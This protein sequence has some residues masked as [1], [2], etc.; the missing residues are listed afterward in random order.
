[1]EPISFG[2]SKEA[3]HRIRN[4]RFRN[5]LKF[6]L[7]I[8]VVMVLFLYY[9]FHLVGLFSSLLIILMSYFALW[10]GMLLN[11]KQILTLKFTLSAQGVER[12]MQNLSPAS[13]IWEHLDI[14]RAKDGDVV[15]I[16]TS[17]SKSRH[18]FKRRGSRIVLPRELDDIDKAL[19]IINKMKKG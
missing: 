14:E 8:L 15:L 5:R 13:I 1:M 12:T 18:W 3:A 7:P 17:V 6:D 16:D 11:S 4:R 19:A 10:L 9:R 2:M